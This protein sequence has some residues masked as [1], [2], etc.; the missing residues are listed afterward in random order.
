[1]AVVCPQDPV[2]LEE[3]RQAGA[4]EIVTALHQ[5]AAGDIWS[6]EEIR[7]RKAQIHAAFESRSPDLHWTVAESLPVS[8]DIKLQ[9]GYS[10]RRP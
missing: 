8:E 2:T 9:S 3:I 4:K 7:E 5:V 1:M 6:A 10:P